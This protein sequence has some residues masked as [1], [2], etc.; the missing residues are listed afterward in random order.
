M[1]AR[2]SR[3]RVQGGTTH[4]RM[5]LS[6]VFGSVACVQQ[7]NTRR[8]VLSFPDHSHPDLFSFPMAQARSSRFLTFRSFWD[9]S[10]MIPYFSGYP[11]SEQ[12]K[13][14]Y[15]LPCP[16]DELQLVYSPGAPRAGG[17]IVLPQSTP[18]DPVVIIPRGSFG[19]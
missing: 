1:L 18:V 3:A 14:I 15:F 17:R 12:S 16:A 11:Q 19:R 9:G 2:R 7:G 5:L 6:F 13:A 10:E 4:S 8:R